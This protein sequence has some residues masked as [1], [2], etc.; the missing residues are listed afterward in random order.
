M[1]ATEDREMPH[2]PASSSVSSRVLLPIRPG[3][4]RPLDP[5]RFKYGIN[6]PLSELHDGIPQSLT[7][8]QNQCEY[9]NRNRNGKHN[10]C[11]KLKAQVASLANSLCIHSEPSR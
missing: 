7:E 10:R 1:I 3:S 5:S 6:K 4:S 11:N 9:R 8:S 2:S